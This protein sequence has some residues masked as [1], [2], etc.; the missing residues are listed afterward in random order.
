MV[1]KWLK[2]NVFFMYETELQNVYTWRSSYFMNYTRLKQFTA[3]WRDYQGLACGLDVS[4]LHGSWGKTVLLAV[5]GICAVL[6]QRREMKW[7]QLKLVVWICGTGRKV[8]QQ[9][10]W[11]GR[12]TS[13]AD[14]YIVRTYLTPLKNHNNDQLIL[15]AVRWRMDRGWS[16]LSG[17][18]RMHLDQD[19]HWPFPSGGQRLSSGVPLGEATR[20]SHQSKDLLY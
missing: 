4:G 5:R 7:K 9:E 8:L 12:G 19:Q 18:P 14:R 3:L 10:Q 1:I 6:I 15:T 20:V 2:N 11:T 17:A 13:C 16:R